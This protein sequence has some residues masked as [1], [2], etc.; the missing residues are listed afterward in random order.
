MR[1]LLDRRDAS[2]EILFMVFEPNI[3]CTVFHR[4]EKK[5]TFLYLLFLLIDRDQD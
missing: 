2:Q 1:A 4:A 3:G 5:H